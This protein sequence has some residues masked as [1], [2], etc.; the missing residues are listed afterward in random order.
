VASWDPTQRLPDQ[1]FDAFADMYDWLGQRHIDVIRRASLMD[2][3]R[4]H[5]DIHRLISAAGKSDWT[6]PLELR[7]CI[8]ESLNG[9]ESNT[10]LAVYACLHAIDEGLGFVHPGRKPSPE[11][12]FVRR[13]DTH[14]RYN[15]ATDGY[16]LPSWARPERGVRLA[17]FV[18]WFTR[19]NVPREF[20][21]LVHDPDGYEPNLT[22]R[23]PVVAVV[24]FLYRLDLNGAP[25]DADLR[26]LG[27]DR[28]PRHYF[29]I[30]HLHGSG[31]DLVR[32]IGDAVRLLRDQGVEIAIFPELALNAE[33]LTEL[34]S[35]LKREA[36]AHGK[37]SLIWVIAG[38]IEPR[39]DTDSVVPIDFPVYNA[40]I[41][42]DAYGNTVGETV[43]MGEPGWRQRKRHAYELSLD[44]QV[45]MYG[46]G[47]L[48]SPLEAREEAI[49][50]GSSVTIFQNNKGRFAIAICEDFG[51]ELH[52]VDFIREMGCTAL[53]V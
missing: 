20:V 9:H 41:V 3:V 1:I 10:A 42:L 50:I 43:D 6:T 4:R 33:L 35:A 11:H 13:F 34:R 16:V 24:P 51:Q 38:C 17:D 48:F 23:S 30:E 44:E 52:T 53:F 40:A 49:S 19:A 25:P 7:A 18:R 39:L 22:D 26:L 12:R 28:T 5:H 21:H 36:L 47:H 27:I 31:V 2:A 32:R 45:N 15:D 37:G 29:T 46:I 14:G 8:S